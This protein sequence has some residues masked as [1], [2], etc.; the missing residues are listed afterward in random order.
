MWR[1]AAAS[2]EG[3]SHRRTGTGRQDAMRVAVAGRW[4]IAAACDGAGSAARGRGGAV[5]AAR[6]LTEAARAHL[7]DGELPDNAIVDGWVEAARERIAR[8]AAAR[9]LAP[10]DFA[11]TVVLLLTDGA[12]SL[13]LHIGDGAA[14]ARTADGWRALTWP[15]Q[16][17]YAATTYFLTDDAP[18]L[19]VARA[20]EPADRFALFSDG[21]ERL[22]LDFAAEQPHAPF[23]DGVSAPVAASTVA[24][25]DATLSAQLG[26]FL[27]SERV[28]ARTDDDKTL[29]L[30]VRA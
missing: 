14:V 11:T 24:G 13:V 1:W 18:R 16:G 21:L 22:A 4:L 3:T 25:R 28:N 17:E 20:A 8:A 9:D 6:S 29:I 5:L 26:A 7:A 30:A 19:R 15:E 12:Q 2:R 23:F 10:R 27:D